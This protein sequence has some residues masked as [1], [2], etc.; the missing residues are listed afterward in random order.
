MWLCL[1]ALALCAPAHA[2]L[3][4]RTQLEVVVEPGSGRFVVD[5]AIDLTGSFASPEAYYEVSHGLRSDPVLVR[6]VI[7]ALANAIEVDVDGRRQTLTLEAFAWPVLP[8]ASFTEAWAAPMSR[9][10]FSGR[11]EPSAR[12]LRV[13]L[14]DGFQ[15]E[16][17][18]VIAAS[19]AQHRY[20]R[21][22]GTGT[23]SPVLALSAEGR[24]GD[25][26]AAQDSAWS[27]AANYARQGFLHVL[28]SGLDHALFVVALLLGAR[29]LRAIVI[30]ISCFTL[31]HSLTLVLAATG[32]VTPTGRW[33]E[34]LIAASIAF[35]AAANLPAGNVG[36]RVG[37][38][39][40]WVVAGFGLLH[41]LGFAGALGE[42]G[43]PAD[44]FVLGLA[45]FNIG[46]E[47]GQLAIVLVYALGLWHLRSRSWYRAR[48]VLPGSLAIVAAGGYWMVERLL[49]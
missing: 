39:R 49:A 6:R 31:A 3:L 43:L 40:P 47:A 25:E 8:R 32:F 30:A 1:L 23:W 22:V 14:D 29:T 48:I 16:R 33:V 24:A 5:V 38:H 20:T 19:S 13:R 4:N 37:A 35:T 36:A 46:V 17:P 45:A 18:I 9:F 26:L 11:V 21:W 28:P 7:T 10:R 42:L 27:I 2:H 41:G 15:F 34:V 12:Q 44:E